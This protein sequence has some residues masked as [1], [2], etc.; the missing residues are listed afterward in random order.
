MATA[1]ELLDRPVAAQ[2]AS[3]CNSSRI[4]ALSAL[5]SCAYAD[6]TTWRTLVAGTSVQRQTLLRPFYAQYA[7]SLAAKPGFRAYAHE[8]N[9]EI[10]CSIVSQEI[11]GSAPSLGVRC[12][13][14]LAGELETAALALRL[15]VV[16]ALHI[17]QYSRGGKRLQRRFAAARDALFVSETLWRIDMVAVAPRLRRHGLMKQMFAALLR[18]ADAANADVILSTSSKQNIAAYETL[19][20]VAIE[21]SR[22]SGAASALCSDAA[23]VGPRK[24]PDETALLQT[25]LMVRMHPAREPV[26]RWEALDAALSGTRSRANTQWM[27]W[28]VVCAAALLLSALQ[29]LERRCTSFSR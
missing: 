13:D 11:G 7:R 8:I 29:L 20:F 18:D 2:H 22:V 26:A 25:T 4:T 14:A 1:A 28:R 15:G 23:L 17:R 9:D 5:W 16:A 6:Y 19:G 10:A 12:R 27:W 3:W 24:R 21:A